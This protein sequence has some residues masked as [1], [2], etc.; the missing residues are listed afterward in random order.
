[1]LTKDR[2]FYDLCRKYKYYYKA[3][4]EV[5]KLKDVY[6]SKYTQEAYKEVE[7]KIEETEKEM[8]HCFFDSLNLQP[9][10]INI[11][12][13]RP[14][15]EHYVSMNDPRPYISFDTPKVS[16]EAYGNKIVSLMYQLMMFLQKKQWEEEKY[17]NR[18]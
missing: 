10:T 14:V 9:R 15:K 12:I 4:Q 11:N 8:M 3:Y 7:K 16:L 18:Y 2:K 17:R 1:M 6:W 13:D 5:S